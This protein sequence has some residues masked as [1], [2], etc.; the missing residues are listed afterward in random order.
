MIAA[1]PTAAADPL[2]TE[3]VGNRSAIRHSKDICK[4]SQTALATRS[5]TREWYQVKF[6]TTPTPMMPDS[7][8]RQEN[9]FI[10]SESVRVMSRTIMALST[11]DA[12]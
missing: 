5:R 6:S 11:A 1:V 9:S 10:V 2:Y 12:Q 4:L 8:S 3:S 7:R